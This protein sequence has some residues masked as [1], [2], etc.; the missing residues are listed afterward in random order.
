MRMPKKTVKAVEKES[1]KLGYPS[2]S[3]YIREAVRRM[4]SPEIREDVLEEVIRR[5]MAAKGDFLTHDAVVK[6]IRG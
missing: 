6:K 4:I 2:K 5:S 1:A 3:E